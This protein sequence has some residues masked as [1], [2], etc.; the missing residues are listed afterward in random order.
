VTLVD[1][2]AAASGWSVD[3]MQPRAPL[4]IHTVHVSIT[5]RRYK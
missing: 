4:R 2:G 1:R 3:A 5:D